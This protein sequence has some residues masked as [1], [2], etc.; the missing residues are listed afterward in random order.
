MDDGLTQA[1]EETPP[2][3]ELVE[4]KT[5]GEYGRHF[6]FS[7]LLPNLNPRYKFGLNSD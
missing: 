5:R 3:S 4:M 7:D 2:L 6:R 1:I